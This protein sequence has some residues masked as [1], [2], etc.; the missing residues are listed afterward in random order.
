MRIHRNIATAVLPVMAAFLLWGLAAAKAPAVRWGGNGHRIATRGAHGILPEAM[1]RFFLD[2]R[3]QLEWLS[4]EPDRWYDEDRVEMDRAWKYDHYIDMERVP[5]GALD[6][7][8]RFAF[9]LT[10]AEA[11]IARPHEDVGF[12]PYRIIEMYQRLA[13]GFA[14]WRVASPGT[15]RDWLEARIINDAGLLGHYVVDAAQPHHTT[16]HY[17]GW[18]EGAANPEGYTTDRDFHSRV[19]SAFVRSHV[20]YEDLPPRMS[21]SPRL[22][23]DPRPAVW[24]Y[25]RS[26]QGTVDLL[27]RLEKE[28]GF[29][30]DG[31]PHPETREF[32]LA[33]LTAGAEMLAAVWWTAWV[34]SGELADSLEWTPTE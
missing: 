28:H 3:S 22:L 26:S 5:P 34:E 21:P 17:N 1:P 25:I 13:D 9:M 11:G 20:A 31:T 33:R 24:D 23:A 6:A 19:E 29:T 8:D 4:P 18:A 32:V 7:P 2:A 12:L 14:R 10:L 16:I 30:P 15:D 27:Y